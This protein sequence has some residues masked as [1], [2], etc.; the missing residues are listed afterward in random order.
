MDTERS[1]ALNNQHTV[2]LSRLALC[3]YTVLAF[4]LHLFTYD[5]SATAYCIILTILVIAFAVAK[6]FV[7][8]G[9]PTAY[10]YIWTAALAVLLV[11]YFFRYRVN[12]VL[13]DVIVLLGGFVLIVCFSKKADDYMAVLSVIRIMAIFFAVGVLIQ[14][15]LPSVYSVI[16]RVF[17]P[18]IQRSMSAGIGAASKIKGFT[19]NTGFTAGYIIAG[20]FVILSFIQRDK[21]AGRRS[22]ILLSLLLITLLMTS[23]RGPLL[24][25]LLTI[26]IIRI[27]PERGTK[28]ARR[29]WVGLI[30]VSAIIVLFF[31]FQDA[32][33]QIPVLRRVVIS[34]QGFL[35]GEDVS[36]GRSRLT[37]WAIQLFREN[38]V[39]GIGWGRY[40]TTTI[41]NATYTKSL[42]AHNVYLQLLCETGIIGFAAFALVFAASWNMARKRYCACLQ[43]E[44]SILMRWASPLLFSFAFQ[45]YFILYNLSG[46]PL[47]DQ[48]YQI[49][50]ALSC[51]IVVA[52]N[53][54]SK[55]QIQPDSL[56]R[57]PTE[58]VA[59]P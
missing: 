33:A 32:L 58:E 18:N 1:L 20:I 36:S 39:L 2:T 10:V 27:I 7:L 40:R 34:V 28:R 6:P 49:M 8:H 50:Y 57:K 53:Y 11:N 3:L 31:L 38:P 47:Y 54:V 46:N 55:L 25:M 42:D 5:I 15:L 45:T 14:G 41:G 29:L 51:S 13:I 30:L 35:S 19:T 59:H 21:K 56:Q 37:A 43:T 44:N 12:F 22:L 48:F 17:P 23:K 24:F 9:V 16:I 52:Y 4:L 26:A